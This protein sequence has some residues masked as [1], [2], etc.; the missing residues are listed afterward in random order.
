[1]F[2]GAAMRYCAD[3][4]IEHDKDAEWARQDTIDQENIVRQSHSF[5]PKVA[6][7]KPV[8]IHLCGRGSLKPAIT[9]YLQRE[10]SNTRIRHSFVSEKGDDSHF[11]GYEGDILKTADHSA[12]KGVEA[13]DAKSLGFGNV[14]DLPNGGGVYAEREVLYDVSRLDI[15]VELQ[16]N[17][18]DFASAI[19]MI[20]DETYRQAGVPSS[21]LDCSYKCW[22]RAHLRAV[23]G[24]YGRTWRHRASK[25]ELMAEL[26]RLLQER[27]LT[28]RDKKRILAARKNALSGCDPLPREEPSIQ[29]F[30]RGIDHNGPGAGVEEGNGSSSAQRKSIAH[31]TL[32][33]RSIVD[34]Q[35]QFNVTIPESSSVQLDCVVCF[36]G[37]GPNNAP[38]R[39]I[40][41]TCDHE[42]NQKMGPDRL[43][44]L[45]RATRPSRYSGFRRRGGFPK[46]AIYR[47]L[48][49][50][51]AVTRIV[52]PASNAILNMTASSDAKSV[53]AVRASPATSFGT[54]TYPAQI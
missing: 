54:P 34:G 16:I 14:K 12:G 26:H 20:N 28:W 37:L 41:S 27:R 6:F 35:E 21:L 4:Q 3:G 10:F 44:K 45:Q 42:P 5:G 53:K 8:G 15:V 1:M 22:Q 25:L 11:A 23:L 31:D 19:I 24:H 43:S 36:E 40:T 9:D 30:G 46:R 50:N 2:V 32:F 49:F 39:R 33:N 52:A 29:T 17:D 47:A 48:N 38:Q 13:T 18:F 51:A 7:K